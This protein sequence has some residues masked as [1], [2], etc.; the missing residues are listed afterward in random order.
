MPEY[1][2]HYFG[3]RGLGEVPRQ[4]FA[5]AEVKFENEAHTKEDWPEFKKKTP[6]GQ[7]PLLEVD[8]KFIP[9]S[10]AISRFI[11]TQHGLAGKTPFE[12]AWVDA[13]ADQWKDFQNDFK[14][15]W[16]LKLGF[17]EGDVDAAKIEHG[18]PARDKFFPLIAKQLKS[19]GSGFLVGSSVT[20]VDVLLANAVADLE[21]KEAGF[22]ADYPEV[23]VFLASSMSE[24]KLF[25]FGFRGI[26]EVRSRR[27]RLIS[28]PFIVVCSLNF[29]LR[30]LSE[31]P[32][33]KIPVLEVDGKQIP[34]SHAI[35][36][37][38]AKLHGL[39]GKTPFETAWVDALADQWKDFNQTF[40]K[41]WYLRI[42]FRQGDLDTAR[43]EHGIPAR[44]SF[45]ALITKQLKENGSGFLVGDCV[46]W[47]DV[48][49]AN[50]V[51]DIEQRE[52]GFLADFP[53]VVRFQKKIHAIPA[54]KK[55]IDARP[56]RSLQPAK[57]SS[58]ANRSP[59]AMPAYKLYY[60]PVRALGEVIRQVFK[61][62]EVDFEDVRVENW[63]EFK[64]K[65]PFGQMPVLE[66]D[67]KPIPQS[68]AIEAAKTEHGITARDKFYPL[69]VKQLKDNGSGF[70]VGASATWVDLLLADQTATIAKWIETRPESRG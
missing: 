16:Y 28:K 20:W 14:K 55:W 54:L 22:L 62:A 37:Y 13:L 52:P 68:F 5:L 47:V 69:I 25:Y 19:N 30:S 42:G 40:K 26:A 56:Y 18:I 9:Q 60:F 11:A 34:Q 36:R 50:T 12:A 31:M 23:D 27:V 66:V 49:I 38:V 61:L 7:M 24:Y 17:G 67:G 15:F 70:L 59:S 1:K 53:E 63:P 2:L 39:A 57:D 29:D 33:G 64:D 10:F 41:Y 43:I 58:A 6:F 45:F 51:D 21:E 35:C 32:F 65:T 8:G 46:T 48:L 4:I 3:I 44:D